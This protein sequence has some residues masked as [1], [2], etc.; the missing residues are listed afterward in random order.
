MQFGIDVGPSE[1]SMDVRELGRLVE[2]YGFE[3]IFIPDHTHVPAIE[4]REPRSSFHML[5]PFIALTAIGE[6]TER[7]KL[8]FGIC[9]IIQRDP[10]LMA[11]EIATLDLLSGGRVLFGIGAG[12]HRQEMANHG[13]DPRT[14]F[15]LMREQVLVLK[16]LWTEE[17][18][19]FDGDFLRYDRIW[20]WPKPIQQPHPPVMIGGEGPTV[21]QRVV[22][23]GDEWFPNAHEGVEARV[24]ELQRL[25]AA[26][27][28]DPI[29][30]TV[31][32]TEPDVDVVRRYA[33]AGV[34]RCLF[35]LP[36]AGRDEV[37][38][39]LEQFAEVVRRL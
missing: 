8:G 9:L 12:W 15:R 32:H 31:I 2:G 5:A 14:R 24:R 3:S 18:T 29:P 26:A 36:S 39:L 16:S 6:A 21:L 7:L 10:I 22:D 38:P 33:E 35:S 37:E 27:G 19:S 28:R 13:T 25:A 34:T 23:Y 20:L 17:E 11:K 1:H 4:G 30:V